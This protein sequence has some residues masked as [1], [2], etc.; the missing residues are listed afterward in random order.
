MTRTTPAPLP[1]LP[2]GA[3]AL[4]D[5]EAASNLFYLKAIDH[6]VT[7]TFIPKVKQRSYTSKIY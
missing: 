6:D 5:D 3:R 1:Q 2:P 4:Q 7:K